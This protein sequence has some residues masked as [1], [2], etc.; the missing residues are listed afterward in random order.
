MRTEGKPGFNPVQFFKGLFDGE[1]GPRTA[2]A[3]PTPRMAIDKWKSGLSDDEPRDLRYI[4]LCMQD[5]GRTN[6]CG[7][8][9]LAVALSF[10]SGKPGAFKQAQ[11][12]RA[13]RRGDMYT[14]PHNLVDFAKGQGF[15]STVI[16]NGS[17]AQIKDYVA[18]GVPVQV[19][20]EPGEK[21]DLLLHYVNVVGY[22]E[23]TDEFLIADPNDGPND[24]CR[25]EGLRRISADEFA[26]RWADLKAKNLSTGMNNVMLVHLPGENTPIKGADGQVR[27]SN[28]IAL[29]EGDGLG[30]RARAA[31]VVSDVVNVGAKGWE[32]AQ[33]LGSKAW[34][35]ISSL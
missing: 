11:I 17:L 2:G 24:Q 26:D 6:G 28:T 14:S 5:Q 34:K 18:K 8:T 3:E 21:D 19:L 27:M 10:L 32:K 31:D 12:D 1:T 9:S 22:D 20:Y 35:A 25:L 7:T 23:K 15:R 4:E 16:N 29:P 30:W 33:D 13:I